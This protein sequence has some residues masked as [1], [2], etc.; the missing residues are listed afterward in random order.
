MDNNK[1][2]HPSDAAKVFSSTNK[3]KPVKKKT[4]GCGCKKV[5]K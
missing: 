2:N 4:G 1:K 5:R 3:S